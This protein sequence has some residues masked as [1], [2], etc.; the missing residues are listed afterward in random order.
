MQ[1]GLKP[2][3]SRGQELVEHMEDGYGSQFLGVNPDGAWMFRGD[4]NGALERYQGRLA[5]VDPQ[6]SSHVSAEL[7]D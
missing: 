7:Y 5:V 4:F 1:V 6:W 3:S 2:L